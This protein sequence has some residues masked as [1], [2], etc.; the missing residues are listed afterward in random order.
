MTNVKKIKHFFTNEAKC[1]APLKNDHENQNSNEDPQFMH[2]K[3]YPIHLSFC[4]SSL[5]LFNSIKI[6]RNT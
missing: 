2:N 3:S 5:Q 1:E 4:A 6:G